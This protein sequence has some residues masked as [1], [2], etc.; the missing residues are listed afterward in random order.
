MGK[1]DTQMVVVQSGREREP[2]GRFMCRKHRH[3]SPTPVR[4]ARPD[5]LDFAR[6][7]L[8]AAQKKLGQDDAKLHY[9]T[10]RSLRYAE[11]A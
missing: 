11:S 6:D 8:L 2:N 10:N 7:Q 9:D 5:S 1:R 3:M 4:A